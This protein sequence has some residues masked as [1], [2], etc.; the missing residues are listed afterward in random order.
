MLTQSSFLGT[1]E[2]GLKK[3]DFYCGMRVS[4][5]TSYGLRAL[6]RLSQSKEGISAHLLAEEECL[7]EDYLEKI[8]QLLKR[9]GFVTSQKGVRGGYTLSRKP[10]AISSWDVI[11]ALDG[12]FHSAARPSFSGT[13]APCPILTHC[14][15]KTVWQQVEAS[16]KNTLSKITLADLG[17]TFTP[18]EN[19]DAGRSRN[20]TQKF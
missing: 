20:L 1:L 12:G 14:T 17:K 13:L 11:E 15:T 16:M 18:D 10:E 8:L 2:I 5:K 4:H 3:S 7:P 9:S 19:K 6:V